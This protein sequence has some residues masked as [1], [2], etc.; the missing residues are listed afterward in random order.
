M[1]RRHRAIGPAHTRPA[2]HQTYSPSDLHPTA[3]P[4][5]GSKVLW[6]QLRSGGCAGR[7][8]LVPFLKLSAAVLPLAHEIGRNLRIARAPAAYVDRI[9]RTIFLLLMNLCL[10]G[11]VAA[12]PSL[13]SFQAAERLWRPLFWV[14]ALLAAL[15]LTFA[16]LTF[17]DAPPQDTTA[18]WDY[19]AIGLASVGCVAA[20]FGAG[21]LQGSRSAS[22]VDVAPLLTGTAM[23]LTLVVYQFRTSRPLMPVKQ[24]A[25]TL[26]V[27]GVVIAMFASAAPFG[28]MELVLSALNRQ[29]AVAV[30][31]WF[32]PEFGAGVVTAGI[33]GALL[34]DPVHTFAG[35]CRRCPTDG[36]CRYLQLFRDQGWR[37]ATASSG[38]GWARPSR[39]LCSLRGSRSGL[40]RC[41][42]CSRS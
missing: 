6:R 9:R 4:A 22:A 2:P 30:G 27:M 7:F 38:S 12:G 40:L 8:S 15:A 36:G 20:F 29:G 1:V 32:V 11:A 13:G 10:F 19:R 23:V 26:P 25:T 14:L 18:P 37:S 28:L 35:S 34:T 42:G 31:L 3:E 16:I 41:S 24:L 21:Y 17:E 33:F 5:C 39:L